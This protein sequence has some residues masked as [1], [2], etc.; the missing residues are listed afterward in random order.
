MSRRVGPWVGAA[1]LARA[2][3][4]LLALWKLARHSET[5]RA[6]KWI[7][8][9][10]IAYAVSPIDLIPD[11]IPVIGLL[12]DLVI[13][14]LGVTLVV[15]LTPKPLWQSVLAQAEVSAQKLPSMWWGALVIGLVWVALVGLLGWWLV[16]MFMTK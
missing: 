14:P 15:W 3:V 2:R 1:K 16:G 8:F 6:A 11:F 12:D 13:V 5:P 4:Y 10:V 9:A 7:A